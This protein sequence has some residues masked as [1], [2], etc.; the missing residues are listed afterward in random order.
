[1]QLGELAVPGQ[2]DRGRG[3]ELA[4][5]Q[6]GDGALLSLIAAGDEGAL[7]ELYDRFGAVAYRLALFV[8]RDPGLAEDVVHDV[9]HALR[10]LPEGE[11]RPLESRLLLPWLQPTIE[12]APVHDAETPTADGEKRESEDPEAEDPPSPAKSNADRA[13]EREREMEE[14][15]EELPG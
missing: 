3:F 9:Q 1:M 8:V 11:R 6:L 2:T 4:P 5:P 14:S 15:G 10:S 7:G 12:E 13:K